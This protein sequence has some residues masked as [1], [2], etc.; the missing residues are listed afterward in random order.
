MRQ[1]SQNTKTYKTTAFAL[2]LYGC[3]QAIEN[4]Q[5]KTPFSLSHLQTLITFCFF[6]PI[7]SLYTPTIT[8]KE[9]VYFEERRKGL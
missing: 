4:K 5:L 7:P 1:A 2:H 3:R 8:I 9:T 6:V